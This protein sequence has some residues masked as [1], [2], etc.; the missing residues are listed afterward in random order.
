MNPFDPSIVRVSDR[1][2][3]VTHEFSVSDIVMATLVTRGPAYWVINLKQG[4]KL[5][6]TPQGYQAIVEECNRYNDLHPTHP[7]MRLV[8]I[9][10]HGQTRREIMSSAVQLIKLDGNDSE[11]CLLYV[12]SL[13]NA[14]NV[15]M[16]VG[17]SLMLAK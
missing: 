2:G 9:S 11:C 4:T 13:P 5:S 15:P 16:D 6:T 10:A 14:L 7:R 17:S 3:G 1:F 12:D 8:R